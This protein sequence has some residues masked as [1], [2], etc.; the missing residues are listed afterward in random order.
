M[1]ARIEENVFG[2]H[3]R[4]SAEMRLECSAQAALFSWLLF[5]FL[6][7]GITSFLA[8]SLDPIGLWLFW[9]TPFLF[10]GWIVI[11]LPLVALGNRICRTNLLLLAI[12]AGLSGGL[13]A[14]LLP[15]VMDLLLTGAANRAPPWAWN[16]HDYLLWGTPGFLVAVVTAGIYRSL[17]Q[18]SLLRQRAS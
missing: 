8:R 18:R 16:M 17:L 15:S 14:I 12:V 10:L 7:S 13:L 9:G 11:G 2:G 5:G 4:S 1:D 6:Y 3:M